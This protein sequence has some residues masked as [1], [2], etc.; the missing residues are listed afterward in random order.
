MKPLDLQPARSALENRSTMSSPSVSVVVPVYGNAESLPE[1]SR[2]TAEALAPRYPKFE[3][4]LIDDGSP[5]NSW[6]VIQRL[7][8]AD[9]RVKGI[10]LS[11]NFGQHPAIAAGF[12]CAS[13]EVIVLMDADLE[14]R[15]ESLPG[16]IERLS[17]EVDIVYT[18]KSGVRSESRLTS[19]LFHKVF[20]RIT[21]TS[22]VPENIGTLRAFNRKVL[23]AIRAHTEYDVLFGPLMFFIGFSSVFVE[24][25]RDTRRHGRTSYTFRKRLRLA[26]RSLISYTDLP[27]R[28]FLIFGAL[29][30]GAAA[31]YAATVAAQALL[32]GAQLPPGLTL[33][34][35]LN[36]L[37]IG[38]TMMSLGIIGSYIF[39]VYQEVLRRPRYLITQQ[40]NMTEAADRKPAQDFAT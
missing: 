4:I 33:I 21:A 36:V 22:T 38:I 2:R 28:V 13:N 11:R 1:L 23:E 25:A 9:S 29:I 10:R 27:N 24:V 16:L 20:S 32:F 12:D 3:L 7:A 19:A 15:P 6:S 17:P 34:V 8:I 35:L 26:V 30:V 14:D 31:L 18:I 39:R 40:V 37:F 5:D